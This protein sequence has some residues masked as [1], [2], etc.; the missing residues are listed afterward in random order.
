MVRPGRQAAC[1]AASSPRPLRGSGAAGLVHPLP[2]RRTPG[3]VAPRTR[4]ARPAPPPRAALARGRS[5]R[6]A[7]A[8]AA[9]S[10]PGRL[11]SQ[12]RRAAAAIGARA[13]PPGELSPRGP[14]SCDW[15]GRGRTRAAATPAPAWG[16]PEPSGTAPLLP[17]ELFPTRPPHPPHT[18]RASPA[19]RFPQWPSDPPPSAPIPLRAQP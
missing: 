18:L 13:S 10:V 6:L 11:P 7:G 2:H 9:A 19:A 5:R 4:K 14:R 17:S 8:D 16:G 3:R 15:R 1:S 12:E